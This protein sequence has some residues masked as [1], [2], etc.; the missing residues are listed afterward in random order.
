V[1]PLLPAVLAGA[2]AAVAVGLPTPSRLL[3][4]APRT[5]PYSSTSSAALLVRLGR[6]GGRRRVLGMMLLALGG[7]PTFGP[8]VLLVP[9]AL[10]GAERV[11]RVRRARAAREQERQQAG[12]ACA[13]LA[14][15]LRSGRS[16][17]QAL[18]AAADVATGAVR[19][20]LLAA[21][22]SAGLGGDV[23]AALL[24]KASASA[25][26][27]LLAGLGACWQVC[28]GT[29]SGL[30]MAVDRL[31][32]GLRAEQGQ[33]L[34]VAAELAGPR[35]TAGLLACL[36]LA[37]IGLAA[38]LGARP[39]HV[40]LHTTIGLACAVLGVGLDGLGVWWTGRLVARVGGAT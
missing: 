11:A 32:E 25:A 9:L 16:A 21:S 31:E 22:S 39:V 7:L 29:G 5:E 3:L 40:L 35:A 30:A 20:A 2:A 24:G 37:G 36:P 33:R 18:T 27:E 12:E 38:A 23:P 13:V 10:L 26:P 14:G 28:A 15:E 17:A 1:T 34:A 8:E 4:L 19:L 6:L